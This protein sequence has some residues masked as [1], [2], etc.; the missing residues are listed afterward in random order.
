MPH[1]WQITDYLTSSAADN[2]V[3]EHRGENSGPGS[4][5][6]SYLPVI[7]S[8]RHPSA[9]ATLYMPPPHTPQFRASN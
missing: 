2:T 4:H 8:S 9:Q 6:W 1:L 7:A 5:Q 3:L